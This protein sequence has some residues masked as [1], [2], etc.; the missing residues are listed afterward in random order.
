MVE[1]MPEEIKK[2]VYALL[3]DCVRYENLLWERCEAHSDEHAEN[4]RSFQ[5]V[6]NS[7]YETFRLVHPELDHISDR[8]EVSRHD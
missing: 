5:Q 6:V 1:R 2:R 3:E 4:W 8:T 7:V